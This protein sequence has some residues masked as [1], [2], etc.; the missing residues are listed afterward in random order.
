LTTILLTTA[1]I[2]IFGGVAA[3]EG[4]DIW[5]LM[6]G[7]AAIANFALALYLAFS[8]VKAECDGTC[9]E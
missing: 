2:F 7:I 8:L 6:Q 3:A 1:L 9:S 5:V 4:E